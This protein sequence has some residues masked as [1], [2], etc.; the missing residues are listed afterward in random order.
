VTRDAAT[1]DS[2]RRAGYRAVRDSPSG[3]GVFEVESPDAVPRDPREVTRRLANDPFHA[4]SRAGGKGDDFELTAP[5][6]LTVWPGARF[7]LPLTVRNQGRNAWAGD[8]YVY[9]RD[10]AGDVSV[11][12]RRWRRVDSGTFEI[13]TG[14]RGAPL[15]ATTSLPTNL[16]PGESA[17]VKLACTAPIRPG[18]YVA[19]LDVAVRGSGSMGAARRPPATV[20]VLVE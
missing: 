7:D 3:I 14:P 6:E 15:N 12:I 18:R 5:A 17:P 9:G 4:E 8:G 16:L 13:A 10:D 2:Y 20:S 11:G 19:E 1:A